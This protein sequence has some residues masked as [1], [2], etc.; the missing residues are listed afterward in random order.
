MDRHVASAALFA[1][2]RGSL[3]RR[4]T[5]RGFTTDE[6]FR[7]SPTCHRSQAGRPRRA[8]LGRPE[9]S[10]ERQTPEDI[11]ARGILLWLLGIPIPVIILIA[12]LT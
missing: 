7:R 8:T 9:R 2:I 6:K 1:I 11:M 10:Q 12:L 5:D 4:E 3:R